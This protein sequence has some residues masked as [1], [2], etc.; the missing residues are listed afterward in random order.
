M[1]VDSSDVEILLGRTLTT[2]E[3]ARVDRL[4]ELASG[5]VEGS[6]PGFAIEQATE[7]IDVWPPQL[8]SFWTPRYPV[9]DLAIVGMPWIRFTEKGNVRFGYGQTI[10]SWDWPAALPLSVT[11][12]FGFATIPG[13]VTTVIAAMVAAAINRQTTGGVQ[14]E[15]LGAYS[16]TYGDWSV[17]EAA[18]GLTVPDGALERWRRKE[19]SVA[20]TRTEEGS[21]L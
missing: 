8:G 2:D 3:Q 4:L 11:Y 18:A 10:N 6:L 20:L 5:L 7:T 16:V 13:D 21:W 19:I 9:S 14:A 17:H 12:T 15:S 1:P